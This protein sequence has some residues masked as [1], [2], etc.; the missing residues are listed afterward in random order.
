MIG[1]QKNI[2]IL[3]DLN[4]DAHLRSITPKEIIEFSLNQLSLDRYE[5]IRRYFEIVIKEK[6]DLVLIAGDV[7]GDGFCGRGF[8]N[9]LILLLS[10]LEQ[11]NIPT[12]FI[13]GNHDPDE[14]YDVVKKWI[15]NFSHVQEISSK[16]TT[17]SGLK[18]LGVNYNT[19][20]S[21]SSLRQ[22]LKE[23]SGK[24]DMVLAHS[25]IKRRINHFDFDTDYIITGHYDRKL[26]AHRNTVFIALDNDSEEVSYAVIKKYEK[27][28]DQVS[29]KIKQNKNTLFSFSESYAQLIS[30][31]RNSILEVN[32]RPT[33][34]LL[35]LENANDQ[36][37]SRDGA[38]YLYLKYLR[39]I[40]YASSLDTMYRM[41]ND[42]ALTPSDLSLNQLHGLPITASYKIS[43]SM[44]EDYLG[45]VID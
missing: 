30:G 41:K 22:M 7:T 36:S 40:N 9:A 2:V 43:E 32:G 19:S 33:F 15:R 18:I 21:K 10:L 37:I 29:L 14:N 20:K 1:E 17:V 11:Q 8:Q 25:T 3:S 38:H 4:W 45:N 35:K 28:T 39:G 44:I 27:N 13:S 5:R 23:H 6:A 31:N 24:I 34:D 42:V 12:L 26:L 16:L